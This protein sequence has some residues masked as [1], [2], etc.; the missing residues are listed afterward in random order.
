M[1]E[2]NRNDYER[3]RPLFRKMDIHLPLQSIL[4]GNVT[5]PIYVD[6]PLHPQIAITWA[7]HRFY[8]AGSPGN[9]DLI[10][11]SRKIFLEKFSLPAWKAG[12]ESYILN[13]PSEK[14]EIF[15]KAM[16]DNKYPIKI[17]RS[18]LAIQA[19]RRDLPALPEGFSLRTVNAELL[20]EKLKNPELLIDAMCSEKESVQDFL[21]KSF[22]VCI[23][24]GDL[25]VGVCLSEYNTG[26][27]CETLIITHEDFRE[28]G[29]GTIFALAFIEMARIKDVARVGW[30]C[31]AANSGS[32]RTAIKAGFQSTEDY[33]VFIG[34]FDD[35]LNL[36][37]NGY[38]AHGRGEYNDAL[39]FYEK[40]LSFGDV[41]DWVYW[42]A[43]CDA[44]LIGETEK[45]LKYLNV[46][47][48]HGFDDIDQIQNSK[49]LL[50]LHES[51][52]WDLIIKKIQEKNNW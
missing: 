52:C 18:Y 50:N 28:E 27:R 17:T 36:A 41:P 14:W 38:Y 16:L 15:I 31:N 49:Y 40:S 9:T 34:W 20:S 7:G 5:A 37:R 35:T 19:S 44:A 1:Y 2:L 51:I 8:L 12:I 3:V 13:Y 24:K 48:D 25:I 33:P 22:G 21:Q 26:H 11:A 32:I 23:V 43:A 47:I 30:H 46:A 45:G 29:L 4:A 39:T 42:G 10:A 6:N